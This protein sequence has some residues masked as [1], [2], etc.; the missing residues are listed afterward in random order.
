MSR[1]TL[2]QKNNRPGRFDKYLL[3]RR[4]TQNRMSAHTPVRFLQRLGLISDLESGSRTLLTFEQLADDWTPLMSPS[5]VAETVSH[6][7]SDLQT[8]SASAPAEEI[9]PMAQTVADVER[10]AGPDQVREATERVSKA[11]KSMLTPPVTAQRVRNGQEAPQ[12]RLSPSAPAI[13]VPPVPSK[14]AGKLAVASSTI[15]ERMAEKTSKTAGKASSEGTI[16]ERDVDQDDS[17]REPVAS[18]PFTHHFSA[19]EQRND[20]GEPARQT[21]IEE[22]E[23]FIVPSSSSSEVEQL[24][25]PRNSAQPVSAS[26]TTSDADQ[27]MVVSASL[28]RPGRFAQADERHLPVR[29]QDTQSPLIAAAADKVPSEAF[30][31]TAGLEAPLHHAEPDSHGSGSTEAVLEL[32]ATEGFTRTVPGDMPSN[33]TVQRVPESQSRHTSTRVKPV[34]APLVEGE[35]RNYETKNDATVAS[36]LRRARIEEIANEAQSTNRSSPDK[37]PVAKPRA[38]SPNV[39]AVSKQKTT[40]KDPEPSEP[41]QSKPA[42]GLFTKKANVDRSPAAWVEKLR[43]AFNPNAMHNRQSNNHAEAIPVADKTALVRRSSST[44]TASSRRPEPVPAMEAPAGVPETTRRFLKPLVGIDPATVP[45]FEGP[46]AAQFAASNQADG[47]ALAETVFLKPGPVAETPERLGLLA[48]EL[49][50]IARQRKPRFV[51]PIV[52][53]P[54]HV[55]AATPVPE[56]FDEEALARHVEALVIDIASG[57]AEPPVM[58]EEAALTVD[59][60]TQRS[61]LVPMPGDQSAELAPDADDA[62][63][64]W[65]GLPAPWEPL[66]DWVVALSEGS[67]KASSS[68]ASVLPNVDAMGSGPMERAEA[69][70]VLNHPA[71]SPPAV[72]AEP[73]QS[74]APDLDTLAHQV[75]LVLKRRLETEYR[76]SI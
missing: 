7:M 12:K 57:A 3:L 39:Y 18:L 25:R 10:S 64:P 65:G 53:Q 6:D 28:D 76:R 62:A 21:P 47:V 42:E 50:H 56:H 54:Q 45:I 74:A 27:P 61:E 24:E 43:Q 52:R 17:S 51:P 40:I 5:T 20:V 72:A 23:I 9:R 75:Y 11:E 71:A 48:H 37:S 16:L 38:D 55:L 46:V 70:R 2:I 4:S 44:P 49:T 58:A 66:P 1:R 8:P 34:T 30:R 14:L 31:F 13:S 33:L 15:S 29:L 67:A 60:R 73:K 22:P 19:A 36:P 63:E 59:R 26:D 32:A 68:S 41:R 35:T 69:G